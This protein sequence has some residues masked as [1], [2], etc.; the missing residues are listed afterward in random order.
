MTKAANKTQ[1]SSTSFKTERRLIIGYYPN[2]GDT[3]TPH[4]QLIGKWLREAGFETGVSVSVKIAKDCIVIIP[5]NDVEH[6]LRQELK[7]A[8][9][10]IKGMNKGIREVQ[11]LV[12]G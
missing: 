9:T 10:L 4:L 12:A 3:S 6:A 1:P 7:K 8:Q 2:H 11:E 5:D